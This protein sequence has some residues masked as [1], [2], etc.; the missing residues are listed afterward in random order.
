MADLPSDQP[1]ETPS[2]DDLSPY[3]ISSL[4]S[5]AF[6]IPFFILPTTEYILLQHINTAPKPAWTQLSHRSLQAYPS[7]LTATNTLLAAPLPDWLVNPII[8]RM[9]EAGIWKGAPHEGPNHVLV[10]VY[11]PGQGI[12]PHQD[13]GAYWPVVGTVSLGAPIVLE[14]FAKSEDEG[15]GRPV[16]RI[17]QEARRLADKYPVCVVWV[18]GADWAGR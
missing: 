2:L 1:T 5:T 18:G 16:G 14:V 8:P 9:K 17:L 4:P 12:M 11:E 7:R 6:Y 15:K 10:N 13:G 3:R